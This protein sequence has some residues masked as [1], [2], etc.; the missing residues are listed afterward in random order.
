MATLRNTALALLRIAGASTISTGVRRRTCE[1][2][3]VNPGQ[4]ARPRGDADQRAGAGRDPTTA[5]LSRRVTRVLAVLQPQ[6]RTILTSRQGR[7]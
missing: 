6:S 1:T 7:L 2:R 5:A 4:V 3:P